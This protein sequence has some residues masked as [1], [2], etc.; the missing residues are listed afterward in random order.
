MKNIVKIGG[1]LIKSTPIMRL[2]FPHGV[3]NAII[4]RLN[5]DFI[6]LN[7][8]LRVYYRCKFSS[9]GII[10]MLHRVNSVSTERIN[11]NEYL[12]LPPNLLEKLILMYQKA[13]FEFISLDTLY[14]K[15]V[16]KRSSKPF[17]VF[18]LDDGYVDNY[19]IA[20]PIFKKYNV[21]F[22]IYVATDFPDRKAELWWYALEDFLLENSD[23]KLANGV[24]LLT[25]TKS[26]KELA[27]CEIRRILLSKRGIDVSTALRSL[28]PSFD[29]DIRR[30]V[31][32]EAMSWTQIEEISKDSLCTIGG[33]TVSHPV[34]SSL[35]E[36]E[37]YKEI[38]EGVE[39]LSKHISKPIEH[40]AYPFGSCNEASEREYV[41]AE[42]FGFK[43]IATTINGTISVRKSR[44]NQ[45][46]RYGFSVVNFT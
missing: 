11:S 16:N 23:V 44:L 38:K 5:P 20:Y 40:F 32:T 42:S 39:L 26:Q 13:G 7:P 8:I 6:M 17:V 27:F 19:T 28:I 30:Y 34:L 36:S 22:C 46:T 18:T 43:T 37:V 41:I 2:L 24:V 10:V 14:Q 9:D 21:P 45:L 12:K 3:K 25:K 1:R 29:I 33:H 4:N 15:I 35:D 31:R